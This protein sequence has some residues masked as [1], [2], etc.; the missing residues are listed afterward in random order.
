MTID[1]LK[2]LAWLE[3]PVLRRNLVGRDRIDE[4][5]TIAVEQCPIQFIEHVSDGGCQRDV[6]L[7]AWGQSVKKGHCLL[8]G[9]NNVTFGPLFWVLVG[10]LLQIMLKKL[11]EWWFESSRNKLLMAGWQRSMTRD[12]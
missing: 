11:L 3:L 6:I 8:H 9:E 4:L 12:R 7:S 2:E 1:E 5:V 10:P